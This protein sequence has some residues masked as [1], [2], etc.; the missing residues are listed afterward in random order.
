MLHKMSATAICLVLFFGMICLFLFGS[1][2]KRR[3]KRQALEETA[4]SNILQS[5]LFALFGFILAFSF[6]MS[7]NRYDYSR[8]AMIEETNAAGTAILRAN[9]YSDSV[10]QAFLVYFKDYLKARIDLYSNL[11]DTANARVN[12]RQSA[13][14]AQQLW[15]LAASQSKLPN[16]L[17]PSNQMIPALNNMFDAATKKDTL[18]KSTI[19]DLMVYMLLVLALISSFC[20]GLLSGASTARDNI[21]SFFFIVFAALVVYVTI[22]L[23]RPLRGFI[24]SDNGTDALKDLLRML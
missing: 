8:N 6:G 15:S 23:G 18:L 12:I 21:I 16:M 24:R 1:F 7:G 5:S 20:G 9:L 2:L 13:D 11:A 4:N 22:D 14:A 19:P 17:I 10:K 3:L